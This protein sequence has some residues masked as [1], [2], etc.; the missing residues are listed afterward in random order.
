MNIDFHAHIL[1][2]AD[3]GCDSGVMA[4]QQLTMAKSAGV[5]LVVAA[6]HFYP[7][8]D[9]M[10]A[11]LKRRDA[12]K[13]RLREVTA[14]RELPKVLVGAE[15]FLCDGLEHL[16]NIRELCIEGTNVI[17]L[18]MPFSQWTSSNLYTVGQLQEA[19]GLQVVLAHVDRYPP[20]EVSELLRLGVRF[21]LNASGIL[22]FFSRKRY[23]DMLR[24]SQCVA[25]GSDIHGTD[26]GYK[27]YLRAKELYAPYWG[28]VMARSEKLLTAS[29]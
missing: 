26:V 15:T 23:A 29:D 1:P 9:T 16:E 10:D 5:N 25:L 27:D 22:G 7:H 13:D 19:C 12:A 11:F 24:S 4:L 14:R 17:L 2:S 21:Q 8:K 28:N 6:P 18:E 20:Q 3:H